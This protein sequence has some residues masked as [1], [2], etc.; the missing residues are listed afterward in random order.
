MAEEFGKAARELMA[1]KG[2]SEADVFERIAETEGTGVAESAV[3]CLRTRPE[4][5]DPSV[6]GPLVGAIT[7]DEAEQRELIWDIFQEAEPRGVRL[8]SYDE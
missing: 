3:A 4:K 6:I 5:A 2:L 8:G 7:S 1:R